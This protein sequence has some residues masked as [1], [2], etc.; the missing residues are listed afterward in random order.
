M[1]TAA[2]PRK[3][4]ASRASDADAAKNDKATTTTSGDQAADLGI[5]GDNT[6]TTS[7]DGTVATT[8]GHTVAAV[9]DDTV[10]GPA[11]DEP[12][13]QSQTR[14]AKIERGECVVDDGTPHTGRA[15]NGVICSAHA[16]RYD[17]DGNLRGA[18]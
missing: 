2:Q 18:A 14:K 16:M 9:S 6:T 15:V 12:V 13:R 7:A 1:A 10:D 8:D 5:T 17:A 11:E 3:A 4:T